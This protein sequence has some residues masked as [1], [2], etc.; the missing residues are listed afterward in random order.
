M[1]RKEFEEGSKE[2][3]EGLIERLQFPLTLGSF[4]KTQEIA[5]Q[6][7][8]TLLETRMLSKVKKRANTRSKAED[9]AN[10]LTKGY[11][12]HGFCINVDEAKNI[13]LNAFELTEEELDVTWAIH[14]LNMEKKEIQE[15]LR[16]QKVKDMIK[17]L[18]PELLEKLYPAGQR[19][20]KEK[21]K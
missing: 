9:I 5:E 14:R 8:I 21:S 16:A 4:V 6:Y 7:L 11:A 18:P 19:Q 1:I 3:A 12:D 20:E 17:E 10:R 2:L 15:K 13:G